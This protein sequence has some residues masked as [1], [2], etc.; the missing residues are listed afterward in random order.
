[1]TVKGGRHEAQL[2]QIAREEYAKVRIGRPHMPDPDS[3]EGQRKIDRLF[4][5]IAEP[6]RKGYLR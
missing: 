2:R 6:I 4:D 5:I 3:D 1:M